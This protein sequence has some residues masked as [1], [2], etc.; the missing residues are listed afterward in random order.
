MFISQTTNQN[1]NNNSGG[2]NF[3][4]KAFEISNPTPSMSN[5][6]EPSHHHLHQHS[7]PA[8]PP[9][10][11]PQQLQSQANHSSHFQ[12]NHHHVNV[13]PP[14]NNNNHQHQHHSHAP[15]FDDEVDM[16]R[17]NLSLRSPA[18]ASPNPTSHYVFDVGPFASRNMNGHSTNH[19]YDKPP[20]SNNSV[21]S[22]S[23]SS[24][25][26]SQVSQPPQVQPQSST[27][28]A[29]ATATST[30][31]PS[32]VN[33][34]A[35]GNTNVVQQELPIQNKKRR[36]TSKP[37][38]DNSPLIQNPGSL[39]LRSKRHDQQQQHPDQQQQQSQQLYTRHNNNNNNNTG[40]GTATNYGNAYILPMPP[41]STNGNDPTQFGSATVMTSALRQTTD[42]TRPLPTSVNQTNFPFDDMDSIGDLERDPQR[43]GSSDDSSTS[44]V[45]ANNTTT[46]TSLKKSKKSKSDDDSKNGILNVDI[47]HCKIERSLKT[48]SD[49]WK[50][51]AYGMNNKPPLKSL[52]TK[53]GTKWRNE[54]ESRTFLR[55]KRIYEAIE[56]GINKG[57][58]EQEA[59]NELE[60][61]RT[62]MRNG[63]TKRK[64]LS[65]LVSNMPEKFFTSPE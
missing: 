9:P 21:P 56:N 34:T 50:E 37:S 2:G 6:Q 13:P 1:N 25:P 60:Q 26:Q 54:T 11:P 64:P 46:A 51:Y 57:Y 33:N 19:M 48:I 7:A 22:T 65:W 62:Y 30:G 47:P 4:F 23:L 41:T 3:N 45:T 24:V 38:S 61:H 58:S 43:E 44:S 39:S 17:K 63:A 42:Q 28:G 32:T 53:Y 10:I 8:L 40:N 14:N 16:S 36:K 52:E 29:T 20:N 35:N 12:Q 55:R 5:A 18:N 49:I 59:I 31:Q 15:S 27:G